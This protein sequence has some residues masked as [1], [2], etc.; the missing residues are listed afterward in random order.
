MYKMF[1]NDNNVTG[2]LTNKIT[3]LTRWLFILQA[4][5]SI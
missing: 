2:K 3:D 4:I 1:K 5:I